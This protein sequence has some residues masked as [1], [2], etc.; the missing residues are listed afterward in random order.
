MTR[1]LSFNSLHYRSLYFF[2]QPRLDE[3]A[4]E[5]EAQ[6]DRPRDRVPEWR[7]GADEGQRLGQHRIAEPYEKRRLRGHR[8]HTVV[9]QNKVQT[10]QFN[11]NISN[12]VV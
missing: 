11:E 10:Y 5:E 1:Y 6:R 8:F 3:A 9:C 4:H 12:W 2:A 7:E